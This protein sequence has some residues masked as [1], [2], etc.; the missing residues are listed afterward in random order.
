MRVLHVINQFCGR[1]GAEVSLREIVLATHGPDLEHGI[2][3]LDVGMNRFEGLADVGIRV[4]EPA[5]S[6]GS[7]L[8][9]IRH[10]RRAIRSFRPDLVHTS[11]FDANLAGR[12]AA[13]L[14]RTPVLT[15]LV[16][17]PYVPQARMDRNL[18]RFKMDV[19]RLIDLVLSRH[20]TSAFHAIT[21]TVAR[22]AIDRLGV[23]PRKITVVP[24]GRSRVSLGVPTSERR[25]VARRSLGIDDGRPVLINVARQEAQKG[26]GYLLEAMTEIR[27]RHPDVLLLIVGREGARTTALRRTIADR[28]LEDSVRLLGV[29]Q[30]V[31]DLLCASDVFVFPSLYEGLGGA[32]LEAMALRVPI[33]A[34]DVPA[35]R[36]VLE[37]DRCA[38]LVPIADP[39]ALARGV[40]AVL[41]DPDA[42]SERV[43]AAAQRFETTYE[44]SVSVEGMRRLY[45]GLA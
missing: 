45:E 6:L 44:L 35:L 19:V 22:S 21:D 10:V 36:E 4:F 27:R 20:A 42:A 40:C 13:K 8:A 3:V 7:P 34:T 39:S 5:S 28:H 9:R 17:T 29:R 30:D 43:K 38:S 1:A 23:D 18:N 33:V 31:P 37:G 11:L 26:Q 12:V 16:N 32:V 25:E 15:S 24:R 2:T 14:S 41:D